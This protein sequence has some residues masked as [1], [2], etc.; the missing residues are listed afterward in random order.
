MP[1]N[2]TKLII[3]IFLDRKYQQYYVELIGDFV[4]AAQQ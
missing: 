3:E 4:I 1:V 2:L